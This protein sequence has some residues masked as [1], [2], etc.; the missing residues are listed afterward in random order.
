ML[1]A[2]GDEE[3]TITSDGK[4]FK[5]KASECEF[6]VVDEEAATDNLPYYE[7]RQ[8]E[9]REVIASFGHRFYD[10]PKVQTRYIFYVS[11]DFLENLDYEIERAFWVAG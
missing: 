2:P 7:W 9:T 6:V 11:K 10:E 1:Y 5:F 3:V 4:T 8:K